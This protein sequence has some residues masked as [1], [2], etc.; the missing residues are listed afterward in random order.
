MNQ[1]GK[2]KRVSDGMEPCSCPSFSL[3]RYIIK[4]NN[5]QACL[6]KNKRSRGN[7]LIYN[8]QITCQLTRVPLQT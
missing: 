5:P 7:W 1:F 8:N 3:F 2:Q 6:M 4:R